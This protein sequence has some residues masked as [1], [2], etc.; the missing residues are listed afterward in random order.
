[1]MMLIAKATMV[2]AIA[3]VAGWIARRQRAAIRHLIFAAA[4]AVLAVL[5]LATAVMPRV[6]IR[7]PL[8]R[9]PAVEYSVFAPIA[10]SETITPAGQAEA[11]INRPGPTRSVISTLALLQTVWLGGALCSLAPVVLGLWQIRRVRRRALAWPEAQATLDA[12]A[13]DAGFCGAVDVLVHEAASGPMTC[14]VARPAIVFPPDAQ[15]WSRVDVRRALTHELE[16]VRRRDWL[17]LCAPRAVCALYWFHPLVWI[18]NRQLS[19]NAERA[20]DDAVLRESHAFGYADQLVALAERS[21]TQMRRPLLAMANSGDLSTRVHAVLSTRQARGPAGAWARTAVAVAAACSVVFVA[22]LRT[23]AVAAGQTPAVRDQFDVASIKPSSS[24]SMMHVRPLPGRLTADAT[25]QVLMQYAYG[26]QAFQISGGPSWL[27]AARYE[28]DAKGSAAASRGQL[29]R[30]LQP[31]LED[32]FQLAIHRETKEMP[33]FELVSNRGGPRLARPEEGACVDADGDA[34]LEFAG[35]RMAVPGELPSAKV[36]CGSA[37]V[38]IDPANAQMQLRGGK[39]AMPELVRA[40]S[41]MLGRRVLD[42]T[43]VTAS[44]DVLLNFVPDETTPALPPPP[45]GSGIAGVSL[46]QALQQ[47]L[48]LR[49]DAAKGPVDVIV[50]DRAERPSVN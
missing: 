47:Q 10:D 4:F 14:G 21:M 37:V 35:G 22:P 45:P 25:L 34:A 6:W 17:T 40:L 30:M 31:L 27:A 44:F 48:G 29:F 46:A 19:L 28:I 15:S 1:M 16:H 42:K 43:G 39:V 33:V 12:L 50:I 8:A 26:V 38:A 41:M 36:R 11:R 18:A 24:E 5:P 49:L 3:I 9:T 32:R 23:R 13:H 7:V 2:A 20:C